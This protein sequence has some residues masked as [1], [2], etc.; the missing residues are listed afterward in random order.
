MLAPD[1][2]CAEMRIKKP[3]K[4]PSPPLRSRL[5]D[6]VALALLI[7]TLATVVSTAHTA[8]NEAASWHD[9]DWTFWFHAHQLYE[10]DPEQLSESELN[11]VRR[12]RRCLSLM[13][14]CQPLGVEALTDE[15]CAFVA[16]VF[17]DLDPNLA[18]H[19]GY[20]SLYEPC[21]RR[22]AAVKR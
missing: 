13:A 4:A 17:E 7:L 16:D 15:Q 21:R 11:E 14:A 9:R 3:G 5:I 19:P 1:R 12:W 18:E 20:L 2:S 6:I 10:S 8:K 22:R